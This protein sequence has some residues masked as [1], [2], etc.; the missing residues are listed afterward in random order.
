MVLYWVKYWEYFLLF[1]FWYSKA[2][3]SSS[4]SAQTWQ[5][6]ERNGSPSSDAG[7]TSKLQQPLLWTESLLLHRDWNTTKSL[8]QSPVLARSRHFWCAWK[9]CL[10]LNRHCNNGGDKTFQN[11]FMCLLCYQPEQPYRVLL[12]SFCI[13]LVSTVVGATN[14]V[15]SHCHLQWGSCFSYFGFKMLLLPD[16]Q[17]ARYAPACFLACALSSSCCIVEFNSLLYRF[18]WVTSKSVISTWH[19]VS[20]CKSRWL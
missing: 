16:V 2:I 9:G 4:F 14:V 3:P 15:P 20:K 1:G 19:L 12:G 11:L 6:P 17:P 10:A 18:S 7:G 8:S 5:I 13:C